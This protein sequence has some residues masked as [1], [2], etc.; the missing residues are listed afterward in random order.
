MV[1]IIQSKALFAITG[2]VALIVGILIVYLNPVYELS[3][4]GLIT[5]FGY[6]AIFNGVL[7]IGFPDIARGWTLYTLN[8]AYWG[9]SFFILALGLF[10]LCRGFL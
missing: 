5:L 4:E 7:R 10:F 9:F 2:L 8:N 6:F 1:E 3:A